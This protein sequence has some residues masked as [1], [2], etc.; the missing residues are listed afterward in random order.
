MAAADHPIGPSGA[1]TLGCA[2]QALG[3]A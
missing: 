2:A 1:G 3:N